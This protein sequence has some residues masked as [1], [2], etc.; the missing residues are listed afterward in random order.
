MGGGGLAGAKNTTFRSFGRVC[1]LLLAYWVLNLNS[2]G[3]RWNFSHAKG[4]CVAMLKFLDS[5]MIPSF[6]L[7]W[8]IFQLQ[9]LLISLL[10]S[11]WKTRNRPCVSVMTHYS[12]YSTT[13]FDSDVAHTF[14]TSGCIVPRN[15][16]F[17]ELCHAMPAYT[18][19][20]TAQVMAFDFR[21]IS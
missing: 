1:L 20:H 4:Q 14:L 8:N 15:C 2:P 16:R 6:L 10:I 21:L 12:M 11:K 7:R 19:S 3:S 17:W 18:V 9:L 5:K 13:P